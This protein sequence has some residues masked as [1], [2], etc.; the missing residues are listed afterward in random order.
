[1]N[2]APT[3][4]KTCITGRPTQ[5]RHSRSATVSAAVRFA[6]ARGPGD[7]PGRSPGRRGAVRKDPMIT[8]Y[9][10]LNGLVGRPDVRNAGTAVTGKQYSQREQHGL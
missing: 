3:L 6:R 8:P 5:V 10:Y 9:K 4:Y 7:W 1:M 2:G